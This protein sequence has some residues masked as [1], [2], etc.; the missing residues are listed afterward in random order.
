[1]AEA[2]VTPQ[3]GPEFRSSKA[4]GSAGIPVCGWCRLCRHSHLRGKQRRFQTDFRNTA[5]LVSA[6]AVSSKRTSREVSGSPAQADTR[7]PVSEPASEQY[8]R[9]HKARSICPV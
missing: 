2:P 7:S 1:M 3:D 4:S 6:A 5:R 9:G 8:L